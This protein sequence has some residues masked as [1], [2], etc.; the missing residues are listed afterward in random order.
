MAKKLVL[1]ET[2]AFNTSDENV[3]TYSSSDGW[4]QYVNHDKPGE[5]D[6][7]SS[8]QIDFATPEE[9]LTAMTATDTVEEP[10]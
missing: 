6:S 2:M 10:T 8:V 7:S 3:Y 9:I 1:L 5:S 4:K